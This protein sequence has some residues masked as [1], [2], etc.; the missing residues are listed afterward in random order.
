MS[1]SA[2]VDKLILIRHF[3]RAR[4]LKFTD[5]KKL[6]FWQEKQLQIYLIHQASKASFYQGYK[7]K[8]LQG[9]PLMDKNKMMENFAARNTENMALDDVMPVALQAENSRD[10]NPGWKGFTVGLSSGTSG[11]R[12]VFLVSKQERLRW[13]GILLAKTLP[14]KFLWQIL[15]PWQP[16][17]SIAFF[18]RANSNLYNTLSSSRID[19]RFYDL[20][21]SLEQHILHLN[22]FP[23]QVLVAPA[24]ILQ[25]LAQAQVERKL[26]INPQRIINVAEVLESDVAAQIEKAFSQQVHQI[27]QAT[28]GFL[29]YTCEQGNLHLNESYIHIEKNW[30]D[31]EKKRFQPIITD[32]TRSTQLILRYELND[33]L[34]VADQ[35]CSCGNVETCISAIEGRADEVFWLPEKNSQQLKAIYPDSLRRCMMLVEAELQEYKIIQRG[36]TWQVAIKTAGDNK[37]CKQSIEKNIGLLC[38]NFSLTKPHIAFTEWQPEIKGAKRRRLICE[39]LN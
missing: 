8:P 7:G 22:Q 35:P 23:P 39:S 18:L 34:R 26:N 9:Y 33:I 1:I 4:R 30:L 21:Q 32:F 5:R 20:L 16:K 12:G 11:K 10:F 19:F 28:E 17:L 14:D 3:I 38:E 29:A 24:S 15:K 2:F 25:F 13:A 37:N 31:V 36:L 6:D 27:Y